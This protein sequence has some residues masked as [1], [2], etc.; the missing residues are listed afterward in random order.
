MLIIG[1]GNPG[2]KYKNTIH[3]L[4]FTVLDEVAK[5][6]KV[7]FDKKSSQALISIFQYQTKEIVLAKP[8]T[9]MNNS[10]ISVKKLQNK[11]ARSL[12][13][14]LI[15]Y[16]DIDI[17]IGSLRARYAGSAGTHNGMKSV[18]EHLGTTEFKRLRVGAGLGEK[19]DDLIDYVLSVPKGDVKKQI[20]KV[21]NFAATSLVE[22]IKT[23]D[24]EYF[25]QTVN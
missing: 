19:S 21:V 6:F 11:Y 24:F 2:R 23:E 9:F 12:D 15:I 1:L 17:K 13:D 20:D 22:Y 25:M 5:Q 10:G 4:G 14:L 18:V 7:K 16:D 8:E 3:N